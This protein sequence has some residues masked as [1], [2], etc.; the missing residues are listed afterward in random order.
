MVKI[1]SFTLED[2]I[3]DNVHKA[4]YSIASSCSLP[5][6]LQ[7]LQS[8]S[9]K[10][11]S[12]SANGD[13]G[14][15]P[16]EIFTRDLDYAP[17]CGSQKLRAR[18][19]SLYSVKI[20]TPLSPENVLITP[21]ASL[22]N[23]LIFHGLCNPGDHVICHYPTY[24][25]LYSQPASLGADVS[26][27]R[28]NGEDNWKL[29]VEEL[30]RMIRPE[31]RFIVINNPQNPTGAVIPRSTLESI[32]QVAREHSIIVIS[33]EVY[34]PLFHSITPADP[35]FP[36]SVMSLGYENVV[37]SGS[38]SKAYSMAGIR[39]GWLASPNVELVKKCEKWRAYTV[40]SVGQIDQQIASYALDEC[41]H[42]LL[43]RNNDL[44]RHNLGLLEG[45]IEQHRWAC[46]WVKP[47][48][49]S[50]AFVRFSKM[51]KPVDDVEFCE[52]LLEK[53][54]VLVVPGN[55]CFGNRDENGNGRDF[56]GYVRI[57][58]VGETKTLEGALEGLRAFMRDG[59]EDVPVGKLRSSRNLECLIT[60]TSTSTIIITIII[61]SN[62][63]RFPS[64]RRSIMC[65][66][67]KDYGNS[68][69][70][71]AVPRCACVGSAWAAGF[72]KKF[73]HTSNTIVIMS[74]WTKLKQIDKIFSHWGSMHRQTRHAQTL[75]PV[76]KLASMKF[77]PDIRAHLNPEICT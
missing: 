65:Q 53:E 30:K 76:A 17:A 36:P 77:S 19:A 15:I 39:V 9:E 25:Q 7:E 61:Y 33:D 58:F 37:V 72:I 64:H 45:F 60:S 13:N 14:P 57:G 62:S 2:Y 42:K 68:N 1:D 31:T 66:R 35:E 67:S 56:K 54:G 20:L 48:G 6:S 47:V 38:M 22:A 74:T 44:A 23:C 40:I 49:A 26:L 5:I 3:N 46:D 8:L 16:N 29:D 63:L 18:L 55:L 4:K 71:I 21:G 75:N 51:G 52:R 73:R 10:S 28:T 50:V 41:L 32:I 12:P 11:S 24:Q 70:D 69:G 43:K 59:F 34:R 27:W